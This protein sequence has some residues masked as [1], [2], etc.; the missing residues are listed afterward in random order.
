MASAEEIFTWEGISLPSYWGG[1]FATPSGQAALDAI[2]AAGAN[3]VTLVPSFFM[4]TEFSSTVR[5]NLDPHNPANSES[6]T[7][8]QVEAAIRS[9]A[10]KGLKVVLK[11][12]LETD[13][14]VWRAEI[15]PADPDLW[16]QS[17]RSMI[18]EYARAAQA[19]GAAMFV[20]GTE[21]RS[22]TAPH[23]TAKWIEII[24]AVRAVYHGP[25]TYAATDP[26][27]AH[28]AFWDKLDVI[29]I[30]AYF[31][32]TTSDDPTVTQ[33]IDAWIK[34]SPIGYTDAIHKGMSAIDYYRSIAAQWGKQIVFTEVG[35]QSIEGT[36][37]DPGVYEPTGTPDDQEQK[38]AYEALFHVMLNYGGSW[39]DGAFL[40]SY[41]TAADAHWASDYTTQGKPAN[42]VVT[43]G[44]SS[45]AHG[46]GLT[47]T[48]TAASD[49]LEGGYHNDLL[50][51]GGGADILWGGAGGDVLDGGT[52]AD[53]MRG[54]SGNDTYLVDE[55]GDQVIED[56]PGGGSDTVASSVSYRLPAHVENLTAFGASSLTLIGNGLN[57][58]VTGTGGHDVIDG[59]T[60]ADTMSGGLG[61]DTYW[62]DD[63]AD[64]IIDSGGIDTVVASITHWLGPDVEHA[65]ASGASF[66][67]LTGNASANTLAGNAGR[68]LLAGAA[69][70]DSLSG[71]GS[72]DTL[73]GGSGN[74]RLA[75]GTGKDSFVFDTRLGTSKT[76][77]TVNFD[78][79][80][81]FSVKDD[82]IRLENRIFTKLKK[83]GTLKDE[84]FVTGT[85]AKD[86]N[87]YIVYNKKTGVLS[88]DADGSGSKY[89]LVEF[90]LLKKSLALTSKDLLVI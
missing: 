43:A 62:I 75:G 57:N 47:R 39:L 80:T 16:F 52:G 87:D 82:T 63:R 46:A 68:N 12:H 65:V 76:D 33:L 38:N 71:G 30:N 9:A 88:Y 27:A 28:V 20:I 60:G 50:H 40:W 70:S 79:I 5:L 35:Y 14:R 29:G 72:H 86:R 18:V 2:R 54:K 19:G 67:A 58:V 44:Y 53:I 1:N 24:D 13:N 51:G 77:R 61:D 74:D 73:N 8:A 15:A 21:M 4:Q 45:P 55:S 22:M 85:Q 66:L 23:Y 56:G 32:M 7:F 3:T 11:P 25:L 17:Y 10:A 26:E 42:A 84:F 90:A 48:G 78:T 31:P 64:G 36:A 37:R 34:P 69:G 6:D 81:D 83:T 41:Q 89:K 49:W 59:G